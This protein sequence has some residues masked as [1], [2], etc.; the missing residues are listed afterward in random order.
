VDEIAGI[1][2]VDFDVPG[3]PPTIYYAI[4][5]YVKKIGIQWASASAIYILQESLR[6]SQEGLVNY[7]Y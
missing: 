5:K 6:F 4:V 3:H 1:M 7:S 2:S